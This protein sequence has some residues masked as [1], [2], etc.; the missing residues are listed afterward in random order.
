MGVTVFSDIDSGL[1]RGGLRVY[2]ICTL[3]ILGLVGSQ[4]CKCAA[5]LDLING[6]TVKLHRMTGWV[7][8]RD[9]IT[10]IWKL[11][12]LPGGWWLGLMM[13]LAGILTLVAD[14]TVAFLVRSEYRHVF[15]PFGQGLVTDWA[16]NSETFISPPRNGYPA[17]VASNAQITSFTN[18]CNIGIY[19][20]VPQEDLYSS[21]CPYDEEILG[22]WECEFIHQDFISS[23]YLVGDILNFLYS[24]G[25]QYW[26]EA[27][28][29][30]IT[31][32]DHYDTH[33]VAWSSSITDGSINSTFEV[34]ASVDLNAT[35]VETKTMNTYHC[36]VTSSTGNLY[37]I[38]DI[39]Y[40]MNST[41]ALLEWA[42]SLEGVLYYGAKS[43]ATDG[44]EIHLAQQLNSLTMVQGGSDSVFS[45]ATDSPYYGCS[46]I[47]TRVPPVIFALVGFAALILFITAFYW[48]FLLFS[49]GKHALPS[50]FHRGTTGMR[51]LKPVPD[52]VLSWILQASR[53]NALAGTPPESYDAT[54]LI[55][56]PK[57]ESELH[58]WGFT[59]TDAE[60]GVARLIRVRGSVAP[61]VE[62]VY[63]FVAQK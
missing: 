23:D 31:N 14:L 43:I 19:E 11:R 3:T 5:K 13:V 54:Y 44:I 27:A 47:K 55:G 4:C 56:V 9:A 45:N 38:Q 6:N 7:R 58:N 2:F 21:F 62:P 15:C 22:T 57:K 29:T 25:R 63:T 37:N 53:E 46:L 59:V 42:D 10:C 50:V 48:F 1:L 20:K 41:E 39:L 40:Q 52:S 34:L 18:G 36:A 24:N 33:F 35:Y 32:G 17:L 8:A 61:Y 49:L 30:A 60:H 28:F 51:N 12:R 16:A 26:P